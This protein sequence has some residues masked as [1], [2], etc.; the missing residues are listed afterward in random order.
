MLG[1]PR[2]GF[3]R[4]LT[5]VA[6]LTTTGASRDHVIASLV[7]RFVLRTIPSLW[8]PHHPTP[9]FQRDILSSLLAS[10]AML[11]PSLNVLTVYYKL[12]KPTVPHRAYFLVPLKIFSKACT[13]LL[14]LRLWKGPI[15]SY[16]VISVGSA[17]EYLHPNT[18][19]R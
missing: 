13:R 17:R 18:G 19:W 15:W 16:Q 11:R 1:H 12:H 6:R 8:S 10:S 5:S 7:Y 4:V 14:Q 9:V 3:I 2:C